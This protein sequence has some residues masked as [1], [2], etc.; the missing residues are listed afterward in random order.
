MTFCELREKDVINICDCKRLG[1]VTDLIF[2]PKNG[3][4]K[5]LVTSANEKLWDFLEKTASTKSPGAKSN[6][7]GRILFWWNWKRK[8][9]IHKAY[10]TSTNI[11]P[12][13]SD[14]FLRYSCL[15]IL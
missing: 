9:D 13:I 10:M 4:I 3:C 11:T 8:E 7:L 5:A 14:N 1:C 6:R 15:S 12:S 2:D